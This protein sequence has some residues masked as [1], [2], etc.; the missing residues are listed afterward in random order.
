MLPDYLFA[1][2]VVMADKV[3][4][5]PTLGKEMIGLLT[6]RG[7]NGRMANEGIQLRRATIDD[8]A[9]LR[10]LWEAAGVTHTAL[11][12]RVT[13]FQVAAAADGSITACIGFEIQ[14]KQARVHSECYT[15]PQAAAT[16]RPELFGRIQIVA[17]NHGL[18]R[19]WMTA[20]ETPGF[21][22]DTAGFKTPEPAHLKKLPPDWNVQGTPLEVLVL[23]EETEALVSAEKELELFAEMQRADRERFDRRT[24]QVRAIA[25]VLAV[26]FFFLAAIF[27][28]LLYKQ[29]QKSRNGR[30]APVRTR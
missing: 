22:K 10:A 1:G 12:R 6:S 3:G 25:V 9:G 8:V 4:A 18:Y 28:A 11:E 24:K 16:L 7:L 14:G 13:E 15:C 21:W 30:P 23:R 17:R 19:L 29:Q 2:H 20:S 27:S 26:I 5:A